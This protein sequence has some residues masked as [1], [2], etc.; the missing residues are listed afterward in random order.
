MPGLPGDHDVEAARFPLLAE[1]TDITGLSP[2]LIGSVHPL[3][4]DR[5]NG[6]PDVQA[7][8]K[9]VS[10]VMRGAKVAACRSRRGPDN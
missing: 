6:P 9:V 3:Y 1:T 10:A 5:E 8:P 2:T 7:L 4:T